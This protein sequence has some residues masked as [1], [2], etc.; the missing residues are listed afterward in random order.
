MAAI[1]QPVAMLP[2][3]LPSRLASQRLEPSIIRPSRMRRRP[4]QRPGL[5]SQRAS[6]GRAATSSQGRLI[7]IPKA[8]KISQSWPSGAASANAT[9]VPRKGAEQGVASRVAKLPCRK[10]PPRPLPPLVARRVLRLLGR[11][12]SNS[13][14]RLAQNSR[15]I[16]TIKPIKPALWN[17]MP[18][19]TAPC[20][21]RSRL[22]MAASTQK[23]AMIPALAARNCLRTIPCSRC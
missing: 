12:I 4:I 13:P 22:L 23:E 17:W 9:A 3:W 16:S 2:R 8:V 11:R 21:A 1:S 5:G 20:V 15:V 18:Q 14:S 6:R 7:P 10:W 19:P